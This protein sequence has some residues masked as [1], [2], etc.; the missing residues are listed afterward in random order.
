MSVAGFVWFYAAPSAGLTVA[1]CAALFTAS[2]SAVKSFR[3]KSQRLAGI[4][5]VALRLAKI[6][7]AVGALISTS[8]AAA[9]AQTAPEA[10][11]ARPTSSSPTSRR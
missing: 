5:S 2:V 1:V 8:A 3:M 9:L 4:R 6:S 10:Q 7:V 11:G